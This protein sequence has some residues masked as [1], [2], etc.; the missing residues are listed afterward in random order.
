MQC[1]VCATQVQKQTILF[2]LVPSCILPQ[3]PHLVYGAV[4]SSAPVKA[5]LD[6]SAYSN[7]N[8]GHNARATEE[9]QRSWVQSSS[10]ATQPGIREDFE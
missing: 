9:I 3:F 7:V 6:F 8:N 10:S 1:L 4:A 2:L 5:K